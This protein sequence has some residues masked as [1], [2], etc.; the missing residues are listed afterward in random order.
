MFWAYGWLIIIAGVIGAVL[1]LVLVKKAK[2]K[3]E[4]AELGISGNEDEIDEKY[5]TEW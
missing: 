4:R 1:T 5:Y 3:R 2:E